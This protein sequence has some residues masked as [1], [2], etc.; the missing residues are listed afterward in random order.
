MKTVRKLIDGF[1]A[2]KPERV[3]VR[4]ATTMFHALPTELW[5]HLCSF[6][7]VRDFVNLC[8]TSRDLR[9]AGQDEW[10]WRTF[11]LRDCP[12]IVSLPQAIDNI[13][14]QHNVKDL[15]G[16]S[17]QWVYRSK[18]VDIHQDRGD[19]ISR[20][21]VVGHRTTKGGRYEGE[22]RMGKLDGVGTLMNS[23]GDMVY[24]GHFKQSEVHGKGVCLFS[25]GTRYEGEWR[26]SEAHGRGVCWYLDGKRY[27]G[28]WKEGKRCGKGTFYW[29][30]GSYY[31]GKWRDDKPVGQ[32]VHWCATTKS[33]TKRGWSNEFLCCCATAT[34]LTPMK[35]TTTVTA[36]DAR[37][38][39]PYQVS[40]SGLFV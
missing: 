21:F 8:S 34:V 40:K 15:F 17:W 27:H 1:K 37:V 14:G 13:F 19:M 24:I 16:R 38:G 4:T 7:D 11:L 39:N 18:M 32:G 2:N 35:E 12:S 5:L 20:K 9:T 30:N 22:W 25:D 36:G 3:D 31:V 10:V 33:K 26:G 6:L 23:T 28:K 29:S